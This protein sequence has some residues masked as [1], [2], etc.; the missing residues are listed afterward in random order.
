MAWREVYTSDDTAAAAVLGVR[1]WSGLL[2]SMSMAYRNYRLIWLQE[3][4]GKKSA[5]LQ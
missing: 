5:K 2:S 1:H 4:H 3:H